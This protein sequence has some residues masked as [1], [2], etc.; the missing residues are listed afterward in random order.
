MVLALEGFGS[1]E[2]SEIKGKEKLSKV[3]SKQ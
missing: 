3:R 2:Q 1:R